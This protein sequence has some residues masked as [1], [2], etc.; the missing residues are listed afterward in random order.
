MRTKKVS[1]G[2]WVLTIFVILSI[3]SAAAQEKTK[4]KGLIIARDGP[5]MIVKNDN[6]KTTVSLSDDT[7]V[8]VAR[9]VFGMRSDAMALTDLVPGL[10]VEVEGVQ[11]GDELTASKVR[12]KGDDLK[13]ARAIQ[14]GLNPTEEQLQATQKQVD[15]NQQNI[16]AN[17]QNIQTSQQDIQKVQEEQAAASKRFGQLGDYEVKGQVT[18]YFSVNSAA[19]SEE[20]KQQLK[21]LAA[22]AVQ[23]GG[24]YM[25]HVAGYT[26][27]S[28]NAVYNQE[29]SDRRSEAVVRYL[30]QE[31]KVPL[32]RVLA[33]VGMG[34]SNP[35]GS[36][37]TREGQKENRRVEVKILVNRG[38]KS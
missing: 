33:P 19:L 20:A 32:F 31:C 23:T 7:K 11:N 38:M 28:G 8:E 25:I 22:T 4:V 27:S 24:G 3:T 14:A 2:V 17:Q 13:T 9:G 16:Q 34:E 6:G 10:P 30:Q 37:E 21:D 15:T 36:N 35:T 26:D 1:H 29:L 18:A 12:F 5:N